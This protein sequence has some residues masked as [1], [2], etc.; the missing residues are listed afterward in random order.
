MCMK[1]LS[2]YIKQD[3]D[4]NEGLIMNNL[5]KRTFRN[6]DPECFIKIFL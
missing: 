4:I 6:M 1:T 5:T 2:N 3:L